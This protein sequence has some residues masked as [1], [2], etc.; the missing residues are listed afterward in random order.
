MLSGSGQ[1]RESFYMQGYYGELSNFNVTSHE[2][3]MK[4]EIETEK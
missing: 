3:E 4:I 1:Q 2:I